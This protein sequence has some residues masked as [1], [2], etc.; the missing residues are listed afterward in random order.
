[1]VQIKKVLDA[2]KAEPLFGHRSGKNMNTH[3]M[4]F[5]KMPTT[6]D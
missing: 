2:I 1:M 6:E 5:I 4:A 3:W